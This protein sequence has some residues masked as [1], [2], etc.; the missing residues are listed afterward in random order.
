MY[1]KYIQ[2]LTIKSLDYINF[3]YC[4]NNNGP[5]QN[6]FETCDFMF[7]LI[8]ENKDNFDIVLLSCAAYGHI[9]THKVHSELKK[10]SIYVGANIQEM[11]GISSKRE[12][13]LDLLKKMSIGLE[14]YQ[15]NMF[16]KIV[17]HLKED[18]F[19]KIL[20]FYLPCVKN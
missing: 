6:Y 9:L 14:K 13:K 20:I 10:D 17:F 11:F 16:R 18:V 1:I 19:G 5:H 8:K 3:P 7:N 2:T 15:M 4:F 12:R